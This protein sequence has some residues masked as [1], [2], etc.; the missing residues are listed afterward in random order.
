MKNLTVRTV[1]LATMIWLANTAIAQ[2]MEN[3]KYVPQIVSISYCLSHED[4]ENDHWITVDSAEVYAPARENRVWSRWGDYR[5]RV[6][7]KATN[8]LLKKKAVAVKYDDKIL[9]NLRPLRN[10]PLGGVGVDYAQIYPLKDGRY[11]LLYYDVAKMGGMSSMGIMHG[12]IGMA[13]MSGAMAHTILS[14]VCYLFTPGSIHV[15]RVKNQVLEE[16]LKGH[17]D[18]IAEY[19]KLDRYERNFDDVIMPL[20]KRADLLKDDNHE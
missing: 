3:K 17:D 12:A 9:I 1:L 16:L 10:G 7:D 11:I 18:L 5:F 14:N 20:L 2:S 13:A 15:V 4:L 19:N 6:R 8:K